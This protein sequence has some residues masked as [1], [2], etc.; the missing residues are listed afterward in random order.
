MRRWLVRLLLIALLPWHGGG[1]V[2]A[3]M[4]GQH[5]HDARHATAHWLGETHHHDDHGDGG[6]HRDDSDESSLHMAQAS[7]QIAPAAIPPAAVECV[8][9][10]LGTE[11]PDGMSLA[12]CPRPFLEGPHR[13]PRRIG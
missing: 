10:E 3:A 8:T 13:P 12:R 9:L 2:P 6:F 4:A 11:V 1:W 5:P 7:A